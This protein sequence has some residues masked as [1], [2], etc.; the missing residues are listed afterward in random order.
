LFG[1]CY[2]IANIK[3]CDIFCVSTSKRMFVQ[4][5]IFVKKKAYIHTVLLLNSIGI[6]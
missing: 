2:E 4:E 6:W 5:T 1:E 3:T